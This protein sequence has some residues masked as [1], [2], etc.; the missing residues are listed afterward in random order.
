M[1]DGGPLFVSMSTFLFVLDDSGA[2]VEYE[3]AQTLRSDDTCSTFYIEGVFGSAT[4]RVVAAGHAP[5]TF[6]VVVDR[7]TDCC[8]L[9]SHPFDLQVHLQK[10]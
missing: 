10:S 9:P 7:G 2:P 6:H 8:G 3:C 5:A 4:L 1:D